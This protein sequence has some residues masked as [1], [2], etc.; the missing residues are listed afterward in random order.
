MT[1]LKKILE[2]PL[3]KTTI[4]ASL[5][6]FIFYIVKQKV[7]LVTFLKQKV[8]VLQFLLNSLGNS[9]TKCHCFALFLINF[10]EKSKTKSHCVA[11]ST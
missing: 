5:Y 11:I 7:N 6:L 3:L 9:K 4:L 2:V 1:T 8:I 10:L